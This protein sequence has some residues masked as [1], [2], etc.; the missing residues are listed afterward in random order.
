MA[1]KNMAYDHAAYLARLAAC[2]VEAGGAATTQY[3]KYAAF[4]AML[5]LSATLTVTTA[6]TAAGH[7]FSIIKIS[8]T[9]T[10]TLATS[11]LGT[12]AAGTTTNVALSTAAGGAPL[13]QG[14][15]LAVYS[16]PD[17]VGKAVASVEVALQPLANV[18]A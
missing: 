10:S 4:T 13:L 5:A 16:G 7:L 3:G 8:G 11:T 12:A 6:G 14:D 9:A 2:Q 18:T 15:I 17:V 1:T